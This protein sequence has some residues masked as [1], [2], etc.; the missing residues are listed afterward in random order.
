[1]FLCGD[2]NIDILKHNSNR[3]IKY[4]LDTMYAIGLYPLID[5]PTRI[6]NQ[7]FSLIDNVTNYNI[8][9]TSGILINY[10]TDHLPVFA[11]C[12]YPNPMDTAYAEFLSIFSEQYNIC[13]PVK[14][15]RAQVARRDKPWIY[16]NGL[17][18][19]VRK[20]DCIKYGFILKRLQLNP[21]TKFTKMNL[22]QYLEQ[23]KKNTTPNYFLM[24]KVTSK[25][26]GKF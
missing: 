19:L 22:P 18:M 2:F 14:T 15:I 23:Q 17:K 25:I 6:S 8:R 4:F 16:T 20:T 21:D 3:G 11:I 5:R 13:C 12:T 10:I 9:P 24:L 7:S 26:H 1:M